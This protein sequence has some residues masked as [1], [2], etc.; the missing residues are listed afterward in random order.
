LVCCMY[1]ELQMLVIGKT[2]TLQFL[3]IRSQCYILSYLFTGLIISGSTCVNFS[4]CTVSNLNSRFLQS[5]E[6]IGEHKFY[7]R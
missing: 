4:S 7:F 3:N 6:E 1:L 5:G 2:Y